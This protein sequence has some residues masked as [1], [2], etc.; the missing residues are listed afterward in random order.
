MPRAACDVREHFRETS[1]D[2]RL[3][4]RHHEYGYSHH[5]RAFANAPQ[6]STGDDRVQS[7]V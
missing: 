1:S 7:P 3:V 2:L 6:V 5:G 4:A